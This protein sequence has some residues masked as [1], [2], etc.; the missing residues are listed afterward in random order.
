[1]GETGIE[2]HAVMTGATRLRG[3]LLALVGLETLSVGGLDM[4]ITVDDAARTEPLY[5]A[6][7]V[8]CAPGEHELSIAWTGGPLGETIRRMS[9]RHVKVTV[10]EGQVA[11]VEY[12]P[13]DQIG[14]MFSKVAAAG[15][16]PA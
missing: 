3:K 5:E 15:T 13:G 4:L 10:P 2:I 16:R 11:I 12:T 14:N 7:F 6:H 1:M 8:A 9:E